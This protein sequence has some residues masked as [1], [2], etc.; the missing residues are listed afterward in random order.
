MADPHSNPLF[1]G[2]RAIRDWFGARE[3]PGLL[4]RFMPRLGALALVALLVGWQ[5]G[6]APVLAQT[7][8]GTPGA[9]D[10]TTTPRSAAT[11]CR[12]QR[13]PLAV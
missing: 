3:G 4:T 11:S 8:T 12:P 10:A 13:H 5:A 7:I 9:A 6:W 2:L 1:T